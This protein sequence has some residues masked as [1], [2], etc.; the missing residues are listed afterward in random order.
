MTTIEQ[1]RDMAERKALDS[2]SR[3]KFMQFGYWAAVWVHL[4]RLC[5]TRRP[6]P[7]RSI[8]AAARI[9]REGLE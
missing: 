9:E 7:F 1:E 5:D 2:L 8:V 3:Y 6:S 4:N